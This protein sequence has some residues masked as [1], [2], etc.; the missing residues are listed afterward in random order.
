MSLYFLLISAVDLLADVLIKTSIIIDY[1]LGD[2]VNVIADL[3][4]KGG[5][6]LLIDMPINVLVE[7]LLIDNVVDN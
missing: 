6:Y 2:Y 5:V 4:L 7:F 3:L 1:V